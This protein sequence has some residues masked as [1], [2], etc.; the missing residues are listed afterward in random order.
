VIPNGIDWQ[1]MG[2]IFAQR[3]EM[4]NRL[5]N[6]HGLDPNRDYL[7]FLGSG[8]DRKGLD[9]AIQGLAGMPENYDLLVVGKD[10]AAPYKQLAEKQAVGDRTIFL[11]PQKK[12]WVY[13]VLCK[14]LVLPSLYEPFGIAPAEA[15]AMGI[16]VLVSKRT[17]YRDWVSEGKMALYSNC[18]QTGRT[19]K[20][21]FRDCKGSLN[22]QSSALNR[23]ATR[24]GFWTMKR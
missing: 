16:P 10:N 19:F 2:A 22:P 23:S 24:S 18:R 5:F 21:H 6:R 13:S 12:G 14:A 7:L 9:I 4:A 20:M 17:G 11:G 15:N 1:A 3:R 8:W